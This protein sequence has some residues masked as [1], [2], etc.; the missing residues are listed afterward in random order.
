[1]NAKSIHDLKQMPYRD[2][3]AYVNIVI[4][5][6]LYSQVFFKVVAGRGGQLVNYLVGKPIVL[7]R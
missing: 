2:V 4:L 6:D 3:L 7:I 1:M 5:N